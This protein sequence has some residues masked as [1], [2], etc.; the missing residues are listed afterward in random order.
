[1]LPCRTALLTRRYT[2]YSIAEL[3]LLAFVLLHA[4]DAARC[5]RLHAVRGPVS[6]I[7]L[8]RYARVG[9]PR[10]NKATLSSYLYFCV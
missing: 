10:M 6:T 8:A 5:R 7:Q 4:S 1:M 2:V 9:L 3:P